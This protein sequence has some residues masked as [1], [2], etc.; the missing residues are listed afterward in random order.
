MYRLTHKY[1][2]FNV[3]IQALSG[4]FADTLRRLGES[5]GG[6]IDVAALQNDLRRA[7]TVVS[8]HNSNHFKDNL[9]PCQI[10]LYYFTSGFPYC[11]VITLDDKKLRYCRTDIVK[12]MCQKICSFLCLRIC[13]PRYLLWRT[14]SYVCM[15]HFLFLLFKYFTSC[16]ST[17]KISPAN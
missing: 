12:M 7:L 5:A 15:L 2:L 13:L 11:A 4:P 14:F 8:C 6:T 17:Q 9:H 3:L 10:L 16:L 1:S